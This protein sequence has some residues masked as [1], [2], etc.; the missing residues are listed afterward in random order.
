YVAVLMLITA[1]HVIISNQDVR[2]EPFMMG[3]TI[4][5]LY[6]FAVYLQNKKFLHLI[7]GSA[8]LA[9][10]VMTKGP[11]T[12]IPAAAGIG[13][14]LLYNLK[15]KEIFH[16][17]WI[18]TGLMTF[19]FLLPSLY[20]YYLQFDRHPEKLVFGKNNVSGIEFFLWTSQWGRFTNTGPIKG[21]GDPFFFFHT[22]LWAFLPWA[23]VAYYALYQK[24]R[25]LI[26]KTNSEENYTYFG[27]IVLFLIFSA[28]AFQLSFYL[29]PLFPFL[30]ILT[31]AAVFNMQ[32]NKKVLKIF[33]TIH[34]VVSILLIVALCVLHYFFSGDFLNIDTIM[35][36]VSGIAL[37]FYLFIKKAIFMKKI[38][39]ATALI[40]LSVNYYLN[41]DFYPALL[42]YQ[43]ESEVAYY[44]KKNNIPTDQLVFL[45]NTASISD[46]LL[47]RINPVF[48]YQDATPDQ[49]SGK[50]V[51][52]AVE[53]LKAIESLGLKHELISTFNEFSVTRL[54]GKFLNRASRNKTLKKNLLLKVSPAN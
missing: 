47:H 44:V 1:Q 4:M 14:S 7:C 53:G 10:L 26:Q 13:G 2:A 31:T 5:S 16:W 39:F 23:F 15:W 38:L 49:L 19:L 50:Y 46:V 29:N 6:H 9:C 12:I 3:L 41:R 33:S 37:A 8:A 45:E 11:F 30:A 20:A 32:K 24:T 48:T 54:T 40:I 35:V 17:Q 43:S 51:F 52:T 25:K 21:S 42:K 34:F 28:S 36:L 22:L 27:F 18:A